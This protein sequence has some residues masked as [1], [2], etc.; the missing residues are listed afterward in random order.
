MTGGHAAES[1]AEG[2]DVFISYHT[3]DGGVAAAQLA[4]RIGDLVGH[5]QVFRDPTRCWPGSRGR[6]Y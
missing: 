3:A 1:S 6:R 4:D 5:D 2:P